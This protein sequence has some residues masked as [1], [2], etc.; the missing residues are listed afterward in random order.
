MPCELCGKDT[1]L[2]TADVEG[3]E[4]KV[5]SDCGKFGK[6]K[7]RAK[8]SEFKPVKYK[9]QKVEQPQFSIISDFSSIIKSAR[10]KKEMSQE[11]FA[12]FLNERVSVIQKWEANSLKPRIDIARQ[13][14]RK[15]SVRL[16]IRDQI[17]KVELKHE[18]S[19]ELTL[20]DF[21]KV[22]KR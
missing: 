15:L 2:I 21:V 4:L 19:D 12:K 1:N 10:E 5:C 3:V 11:D 13:L 14:E 9:Q 6:I 7:Q 16:V 8:K 20:G 22:R 17:K 18:K